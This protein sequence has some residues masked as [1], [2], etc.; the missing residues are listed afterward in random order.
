MFRILPRQGAVTLEGVN[1]RVD[2]PRRKKRIPGPNR[3]G[4][5]RSNRPLR[6][7]GRG[8]AGL[9]LRKLPR[10]DYVL[11]A[12]ECACDRRED[13]EEVHSMIEGDELEIA[14]DELLYLV[15]DC[16][17][18]MEAHNLLAMLALEEGN[19]PVARGHFGFAFETGLKAL[20][21]GFAGL[22][23]AEREYNRQFFD[24]GR[25]VAR[26]LVAAGKA[27]EAREILERL[28]RFDPS[29]TQ[30]QALLA[31]LKSGKSHESD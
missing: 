17:G 28:A 23:P 1:D 22:L 14:R 11:V 31:E 16:P 6:P 3:R 8:A 2:Q 19:I 5:E 24:A 4:S 12:P 21:A 18:F 7:A 29:E 25:G 20:P 26:C 30:T 10:G 27:T 15:A 9:S 13:L